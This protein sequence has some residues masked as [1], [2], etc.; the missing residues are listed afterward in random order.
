MINII[1]SQY[2]Y[3]DCPIKQTK[4]KNMSN[5]NVTTSIYTEM[6]QNIINE[7]VELLDSGTDQ[8]YM[9]DLSGDIKKVRGAISSLVKKD[10]LFVD[11]EYGN[12]ISLL[13]YSDIKKQKK[14]AEFEKLHTI[15][16]AADAILYAMEQNNCSNLDEA[17]PLI[18]A[19]AKNKI[20]QRSFAK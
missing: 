14:F 7:M 4:T 2:K 11:K 18:L 17:M 15:N 5:L 19:I 1:Y 8:I 20:H 12:L 6:E 13:I 16:K 9:G 3:V 10:V